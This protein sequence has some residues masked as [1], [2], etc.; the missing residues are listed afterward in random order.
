MFVFSDCVGLLGSR[1]HF[2]RITMNNVIFGKRNEI[3]FLHYSHL[4]SRQ[5]FMFNLVF[6]FS[7]YSQDNDL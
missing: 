4:N 1:S 6:K 2:I 3:N 5:A 7:N